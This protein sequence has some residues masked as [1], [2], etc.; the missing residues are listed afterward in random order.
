MDLVRLI[1]LEI[2]RTPPEDLRLQGLYIQGYDQIAVA[3]HAELLIEAGLLKG[4]SLKA[5]GIGAVA[6]SIERLTWAGHEF[7]DAARNE[8]VWNKAKAFVQEKAGTVSFD[9]LKVLLVEMGKSVAMSYLP[10]H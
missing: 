7:L 5:D 9:V 10:K 6:V 2:E 3:K 4:T 8:T 1:L